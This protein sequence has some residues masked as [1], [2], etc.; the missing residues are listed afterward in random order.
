MHIIFMLHITLVLLLSACDSQTSPRSTGTRDTKVSAKGTAMAKHAFEEGTRLG[1]SGEYEAAV[2][3]YSRAIEL[4]PTYHDAYTFRGL[5]YREMGNFTAAIMDLDALV[6][7]EPSAE[8]Y[9]LR[10]DTYLYHKEFDKAIADYDKAISLNPTD[11]GIYHN[12]GTA[13]SEKGEYSKA[14]VDI[15]KAIELDPNEPKGFFT[16]AIVKAKQGIYDD[17]MVDAEEALM[18]AEGIPYLRPGQARETDEF[19]FNCL[20]LIA[21]LEKVG[22]KRVRPSR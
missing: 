3:A 5:T 11:T 7:L 16:R 4:D 10:A 17:A 15:E 19:T 8:S 22:A 2:E 14:L 21:D 9:R 18:L 1:K 6:N 13:Y 12:R 20:R